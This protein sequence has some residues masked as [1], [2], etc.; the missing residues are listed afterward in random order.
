MKRNLITKQRV[1]GSGIQEESWAYTSIETPPNGSCVLE[2][3]LIILMSILLLEPCSC[4][5]CVS[6]LNH[7]SGERDFR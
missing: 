7:D 2:K 4:H 5:D 1:F 3:V 6:F